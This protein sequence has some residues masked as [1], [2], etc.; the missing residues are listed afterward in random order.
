MGVKYNSIGSN[1]SITLYK[2]KPEKDVF[3]HQLVSNNRKEKCCGQQSNKRRKKKV[4]ILSREDV[5][6]LQTIG[7]K[8][9][10][11]NLSIIN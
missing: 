1:G 2:R 9:L 10:T 6:F 3:R 4:A 11:H 7:C 8:V 5:K